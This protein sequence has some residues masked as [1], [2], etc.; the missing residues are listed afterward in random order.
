V[1]EIAALS[2]ALLQRFA[3]FVDRLPAD[4]VQDLAEG[5]AQFTYIPIGSDLPVVPKQARRTAA[6]KAATPKAEL[7]DMV[8]KLE[9]AASR[10]EGRVLLQPLSAADVRAV[11]V[12]AG[13]T[14]VSRTP[15]ADLIEEVV[16]LLIGGRL[17]FAAIRQS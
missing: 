2:L 14:G 7:V 4:Q 11:A 6:K 17:T 8:A 1:S 9:A 5:R 13:M 15:K 16:S 10:D 12:A 3:E